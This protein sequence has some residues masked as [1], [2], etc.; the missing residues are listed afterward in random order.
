MLALANV[1]G[2]LLGPI[3]QKWVAIRTMI[4]VGQFVMAF[5]LGLIVLFQ[6]IDVPVMI[7][8]SMV[9]MIVTYQVTIGSYYFVYVS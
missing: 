6:I 5:F 1:I 3:V 7:L 4:I 8:V 2:A 9:C